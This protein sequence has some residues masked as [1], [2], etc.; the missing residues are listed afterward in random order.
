[1]SQDKDNLLFARARAGPRPTKS[2]WLLAAAAVS[3]AACQPEAD[4]GEPQARAVRAV[5]VAGSEVGVPI[6]LTGRIEARDEASLAF[7]I[8]G[9]IMENDLKLGDQVKP[10]QVLARLESQNEQNALHA[11]QARLTAAQ[12]Q[13]TQARNQFERQ[14]TLLAGG[15][16]TRPRFDEARQALQTAQS[17]VDDA[18]AQLK[19]ANDQLS[20]TV[21]KADAPGV[22]TMI[23]PRA[24]EVVQAGQMIAKVARQGGRDAVFDAPAQSIGLAP[25]DP[26]IKVNLTEDATVTAT[27]RVREV[28]PQADPVTRTFEVRV[29]LIDPPAAMRLGATVT[30]QV[31]A[32]ATTVFEIPA[33]ALTSFNRQPAVWVVDPSSRIVSMQNVEVVRFDQETVAVSGGLETGE[34]VVTAGVQA[35]HPGQKVQLLGWQP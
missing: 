7:R 4:K 10:G 21:L 14:E 34:I 12:A 31:Q 17:Q 8:S 24:G 19:T 25:A 26:E 5:T 20:F 33:A 3:L 16:T 9:R 29:G 2:A 6:T 11:A 18:Q 22:L 23:G 30:G 15:W 28:S 27:G 32:E 1:M 13:L 35:L